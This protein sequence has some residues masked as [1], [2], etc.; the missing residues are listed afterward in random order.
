[1]HQMKCDETDTKVRDDFDNF[2]IKNSGLWVLAIIA[3]AR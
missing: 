3:L 1:M 2:S